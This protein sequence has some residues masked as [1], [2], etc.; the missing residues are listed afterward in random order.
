MNKTDRNDVMDELLSRAVAIASKWQKG[1]LPRTPEENGQE[2]VQNEMAEMVALTIRTVLDI[3]FDPQASRE[4][5]VRAS[6]L[7]NRPPDFLGRT[8]EILTFELTRDLDRDQLHSIFPSITSHTASFSSGYIEATLS[9]VLSDR[10]MAS[11]AIMSD[12]LEVDE[13]LR[14]TNEHLEA[15]VEQ[16]TSQLKTLNESLSAEIEMRKKTEE[17]LK[18][19]DTLLTAAFDTTLMW[20]GLLDPDGRIIL[21]NQQSAD[22]IGCS[23]EDLIGVYFWETPWWEKLPLLKERVKDSIVRARKGEYIRFDVQHE[24][25]EGNIHDI[26]LS[27]RPVKNE[28]GD[29]VYLIPEGVDITRRKN[30]ERELQEA[31]DKLRDFLDNTSDIMY[32]IDAGGTITYVSQQIEKLGL[33][34]EQV[35]GQKIDNLVNFLHPQDREMARES[36]ES[37]YKDFNDSS[38]IYRFID[39]SGKVHWVEDGIIIV[40]DEN[41]NLVR[42]NGILR[43]ITDRKQAEEELI[44]LNEVLRLINRIMRHDIKNRLTV[45]YALIGLL[46]ERKVYDPAIL[47][48]TVTSVKRSIELTRRMAELESLVQA[49]KDKKE[50]D[51]NPLIRDI[52]NDYPLKTTIK[53]DCRIVADDAL[54]SVFDN[55][56][57]NAVVHGRASSLDV[58]ITC[59]D[60]RV[61][62]DISDNGSGMPDKIKGM[63]FHENFSW[64][65]EKGSGLG[66]FIVSKVMERYGG[67]VDIGESKGTGARFILQFP[68]PDQD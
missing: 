48:Y 31:R 20:T 56:I 12:L 4:L 42:I 51:L 47:K 58:E 28:T 6:R 44:K 30:I 24:D 32:S 45:V 3:P 43:D 38:K 34:Q 13:R 61:T 66:L 15:L 46:M 27:I 64:G 53:G 41:G 25:L 60:S 10:D 22:F 9:H 17:D 5:G 37:R 65:E 8:L 26:E 33:T 55:L 40:K 29:V 16:R 68:L 11:D 52:A 18:R 57:A 36:L 59:E 23:R 14:Q 7:K 2:I 50:F 67:S 54:A 62:V 39:L 49:S 35:V 63:L 1:A 21:P 19:R